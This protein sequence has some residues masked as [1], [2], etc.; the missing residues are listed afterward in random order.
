MSAVRLR[1]LLTPSLRVTALAAA[2]QS[3]RN[4][5]TIWYPDAEF[6]REF[7]TAGTL[8]KLWFTRKT[9]YDEQLGLDKYAKL[10][11]DAPVHS[12]DY[13]GKLREKAL[14]NMILNFGP[15]HPAAH[16]VL[17]LVLKLEGEVIIKAMPHIGLLHR[18]TEKLMEHKTYT[19]CMPYLDR[20]DYVTMLCS[21][22]AFAL[23]IEKLL[24]IQV[25]PR[26]K[27]I[28]TLFAELNRVAN[29]AFGVTTHA[30]DI[31]AMTPLF[32]L[33]EEREK[34]FEFNERVSGA[35]MHINYFRP[36]G[37]SC[38]LPLGL[39]DDIY[40]W[41]EKFPERIDELE[42]MLTDNR[43][44]KARTIDIGLVSAADALN[45]GYSGVM[46]RSSGVKWDVRKASPYD[47]YDQVEFDV[48]IGTKGDCYDRY[49]CRVEEMRQS[50]RIIH[51]CLN[52]MPAGEVKVEDHKITPP[53][54]AEM[55]TSMES[56]IHHF[57]FFTE[58]FQVPPGACYVPIEAPNGEFGTYIVANG[59]SKPYRVFIRGPSF[60]HLASLADVAYMSLI[61]DVVAIV[62]TLDIVFGEVD[63]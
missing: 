60:A 25:P 27:W 40:D 47:A 37:V 3:K 19:Q 8:G 48:P 34:L 12:D 41:A 2:S 63:R 29:H 53:K 38:D 30:L 16:G 1:P 44:W 51:Q 31:G 36:G 10:M 42:D 14:E 58:G 13:K 4:S 24:G 43:I 6:E 23:S 35:R 39:L 21:E 59:T 5:H 49:L 33:F 61:A 62:G 26:A 20:L 56:L 32:W 28:R 11:L 46:L 15:Q 52:K 57:K 7:K 9:D 54:R 22:Q 17:R 18:G 50:L 45:Y 55:K